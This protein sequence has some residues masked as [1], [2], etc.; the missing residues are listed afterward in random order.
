MPL[1]S[2]LFEGKSYHLCCSLV[3][4]TGLT[5]TESQECHTKG[6]KLFHKD[7][8][9]ILRDSPNLLLTHQAV[10]RILFWKKKNL[11]SD[12]VA[13]TLGLL[14]DHFKDYTEKETGDQI[15]EFASGIRNSANPSVALNVVLRL[16]P[17]VST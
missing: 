16:I 11:I 1:G 2:F 12:R 7:E 8:C 5:S 4:Q 9:K 10:Y 13:A 15:F 6:W 14:D 17:A 3:G